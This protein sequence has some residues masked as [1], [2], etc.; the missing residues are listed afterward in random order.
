[1]R[2]KWF[3]ATE[4]CIGM[5]LDK[6]GIWR[7]VFLWLIALGCSAVTCSMIFIT[8]RFGGT[9]TACIFGSL[10]AVVLSWAVYKG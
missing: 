9:A 4:R 6:E 10:A 1:M 5:R 7:V 3:V 2:G 8:L